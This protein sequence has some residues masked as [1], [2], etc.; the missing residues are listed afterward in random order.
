MGVQ[1]DGPGGEPWLG[2]VRVSNDDNEIAIII[3][4]LH[5]AGTIGLVAVLVVG[6]LEDARLAVDGESLLKK[7]LAY[8][9]HPI[10]Q[11]VT[12]LPKYLFS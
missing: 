6:M 10:F 8:R 4:L 12:N 2:L 3:V 9:D 5:I 1:A 7:L 11:D